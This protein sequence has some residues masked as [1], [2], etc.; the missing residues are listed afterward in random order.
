MRKDRAIDLAKLNKVYT[1]L[2]SENR[3]EYTDGEMKITILRTQSPQI[4]R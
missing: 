2:M 4:H 1:K 3:L